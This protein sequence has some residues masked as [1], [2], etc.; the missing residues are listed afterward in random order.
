MQ[1][2]WGATTLQ[3]MSNRHMVKSNKFFNT[4]EWKQMET[5][6]KNKAWKIARS[7]EQAKVVK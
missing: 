5:E 2:G 1:K 7:G 4:E 6:V 3:I